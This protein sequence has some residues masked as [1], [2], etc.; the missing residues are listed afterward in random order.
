VWVRNN[1]FPHKW[2]PA[3]VISSD[4]LGVNVTFSFSFT[5]NDA[6]SA[7]S[8]FLHSHILPFEEAFPF[9][10]KRDEADLP[11][12]HSALRF[13]GRNIVSGLRCPCLMGLNGPRRSSGFDPAGVL[14]FVLDAAVSPW[15]ELP[16]FARAVR[17]VAQVHAFRSC[18]SVKQ[19][20]LYKQAKIAGTS[21]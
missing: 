5:Q 19:K 3:L 10:A 18:C 8:Y 17:V 15:V 4:N 6:V 14:G 21:I 9:L 11:L 16:S 1:L 20:K 7:S 13:L 12:H 2:L